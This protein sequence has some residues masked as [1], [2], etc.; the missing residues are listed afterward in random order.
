MTISKETCGEPRE[1]N[2]R[3]HGIQSYGEQL[4]REDSAP[5][6]GARCWHTLRIGYF[7]TRT[8]VS[9]HWM[10]AA[11]AS[12][13]S[14]WSAERLSA[15]RTSAAIIAL[16]TPPSQVRDVLANRTSPAGFANG[17]ATATLCSW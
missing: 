11:M 3:A 9:S 14:S 1:R 12:R 2:A 8:C 13:R 7:T 5:H 16:L 15:T 6:G 10:S 17:D 4:G